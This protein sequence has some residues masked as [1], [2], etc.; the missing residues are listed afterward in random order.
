MYGRVEVL[1]CPDQAEVPFLHQ[2]VER[3][4]AALVPAN[5]TDHET[6]IGGDQLGPGGSRVTVF[7][8]LGEFAF[9]TD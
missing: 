3:V 9:F 1:A 5:D 6:Q 4:R 2:V 8:P 7:D